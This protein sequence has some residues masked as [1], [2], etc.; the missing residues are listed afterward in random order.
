MNILT[1]KLG[2]KIS[3]LVSERNVRYMESPLCIGSPHVMLG[4]WI[5][6]SPWP[7]FPGEP[8]Q[9]QLAICT[10]LWKRQDVFHRNF[11]GGEK[12]PI[13]WGFCDIQNNLL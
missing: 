11:V 5:K 4:I 3:I 2:F 12:K 9:I 8:I 7:F 10:C 13:G 6:T 1:S